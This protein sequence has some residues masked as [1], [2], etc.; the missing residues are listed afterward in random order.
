M[1]RFFALLLILLAGTCKASAQCCCSDILVHISLKDLAYVHSEREFKVQSLDEHHGSYLS[2]RDSTDGRLM[3]RMDVGCGVMERRFTITHITTG[4]R[5][6]LNV[7]FVGFDGGHPALR[8]PFLPGRHEVDYTRLRESA[9]ALLPKDLLP[10]DTA[11]SQTVHCGACAVRVDR[12]RTG[13]TLEPL[14]LSE[15]GCGPGRVRMSGAGLAY[16]PDGQGA[17]QANVQESLDRKLCF[18]AKGSVLYH[19]IASINVRGHFH[20]RI[21]HEQ[22]DRVYAMEIA[23]MDGPLWIPAW[24]VDAD[25]PGGER[26]VSSMVRFTLVAGRVE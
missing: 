21:D 2:D 11:T 14:N 24:V 22:T 23:L 8:V 7:L 12:D 6:E 5:M 1:T 13:V 15:G 18:R 20:G 16:C 25:T 9:R 10:S 4:E 26:E 3:V 19:G 17:F